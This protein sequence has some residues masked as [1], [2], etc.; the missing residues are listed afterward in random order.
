LE[1]Q[2]ASGV[3]KQVGLRFPRT[4]LVRAEDA[5]FEQRQEADQPQAEL[6]FCARSARGDAKRQLQRS[7]KLDR[8]D[9]GSQPFAKR[10]SRSRA[11]R[12]FDVARVTE[13]AALFDDA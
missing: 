8:S 4:D 13:V 5:A 11:N 1:T 9:D 3:E 12:R 6:D 2:G 7:N 10:D